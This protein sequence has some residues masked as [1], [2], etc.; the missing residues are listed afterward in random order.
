MV[1]LNDIIDRS[2]QIIRCL[3]GIDQRDGMI[4]VGIAVGAI[5]ATVNRSTGFT[6]NMMM[7]GREVIMSLNLMLGGDGEEAGRGCTF[8]VDFKDGCVEAHRKAP[9][10]TAYKR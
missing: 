2:V 4:L 3:S 8:R 9:N 5:R 6:P 7:F 1:K 10:D